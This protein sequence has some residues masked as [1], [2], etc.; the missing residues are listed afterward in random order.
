MQLR[1]VK[2]MS[3]GHSNQKLSQKIDF[4]EFHHVN[5]L[6]HFKWVATRHLWVYKFEE[7]N[8]EAYDVM[9]RTL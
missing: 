8:H 6:E 1:Q 7:K 9:V 3:V 4:W 2:L 5:P